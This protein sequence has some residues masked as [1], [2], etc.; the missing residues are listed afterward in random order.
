[1]IASGRFG[2]W[3][4]PQVVL[5]TNPAANAEWTQTVPATEIWLVLAVSVSCAQAATQTPQ[6]LLR[7]TDGTSVFFESFGCT[8]AQAVSTTCQYTW[9]PGLV[10]SG[11]IGATTNVHAVAPLP[12]NLICLPGYVISSGTTVGLGANT[13]Y[14]APAFYVVKGS[15]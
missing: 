2:E 13:D 6:P 3:R 9:A 5:G 1:M 10:I 11:L 12:E 4:A 7:I 14:G 15:I 8:T